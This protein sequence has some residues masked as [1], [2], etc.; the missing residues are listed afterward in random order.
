MRSL[1]RCCQPAG[2]PGNEEVAV[3]GRVGGRVWAYGWALL[4]AVVLITS[5][6][7]AAAGAS[8]TWKIQASPN[9]TVPS[10]QVQ[11]VSCR[12]VSACT[13]VG[14]Y[15]DSA[16]RYVPLAETWNGSSWTQQAVPSP[17]GAEVPGLN[18]V[19]CVSASFCEAVGNSDDTAPGDGTGIA[20][21]WNGSSWSAQSVP[22]PAGATSVLLKAVSCDTASFCEAVG[23]YT[24]DDAI[25]SLAEEWNGT[26]WA[27]QSTPN[28]AGTTATQLDGVSCV[29]A[30]FCQAVDFYGGIAEAWNGTTWT[31]QTVPI[32]SGMTSPSLLSVSC[33]SQTFC[34]AV[35]MYVNPDVSNS[36]TLFAERWNGASWQDQ[37][38]PQTADGQLLDAVSCVSEAF[39]EAVGYIEVGVSD[40]DTFHALAEV[41]RGGAWHLQHPPSAPGTGMTLLTGVS[42]ASAD[43]CEA[44]GYLPVRM[45]VWNGTF[46]AMQ[47]ALSPPGAADN[48][49][50]AVSCVTA[51]FC[52]A[53]GFD[54]GP[55]LGLTE[56][57]NGSAWKLQASAGLLPS[58]SAVSCV[59]ASFCEAVGSLTGDAA[60][61]WNG[62][63]WQPQPTP[64][65]EYSA[66]SCASA[67]F[68]QAVGPN[69]A[70]WNG[71]SWSPG[72]LPAVTNGGYTGVSCV[73][74]SSCEV[75]GT[76]RATTDFAAAAHWNGT[77]WTAQAVPEPTGAKGA[78]L[79]RVSCP[80][81][82]YCE[83]VGDSSLGAYSAA[84]NGT[85]WTVQALLPV[86]SG[87]SSDTLIGVACT[88]ATACTT[89]GDSR[90]S[91][92]PY[93]VLTLAEAWNGTSWSIQ[94]TPS[95]AAT[96]NELS[97]VSC[98]T[99][100]PC[101]AVGSA[102]DPGGYTATL[103]EATG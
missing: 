36:G 100:G 96:S 31:A 82:T 65:P 84:W 86:P 66:V 76:G 16:G 79:T 23:S 6:S 52:E 44:G 12:S 9:V 46:W 47:Q 2:G 99:A 88:S 15:L 29:S 35:G 53:V 73:S 74:A 61:V 45:E 42:C 78:T 1:D 26:A 33:P 10:G 24:A 83:A 71:T 54:S 49:L 62:T 90:E 51:A 17:A 14:Y 64:G 37:S 75:V 41:W 63:S 19:S 20:E 94:S 57:W 7:V 97:G 77:S 3:R 89:V 32:P 25:L 102:P 91:A 67:T 93:A 95:P 70:V 30:M 98:V 39:C 87:A 103:V 101:F 58:L 85:A 13:A 21:E 27:V 4:G 72:S 48:T 92:S 5:V 81:A 59:T 11:A 40:G 56:V 28:Q 55:H 43:A 68:C 22:S 60:A 80:T 34:E 38:V 69:Y 18:G 50:D 8:A